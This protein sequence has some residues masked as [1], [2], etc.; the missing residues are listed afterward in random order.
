MPS[1]SMAGAT[2]RI[3][4][5]FS[6]SVRR[7]TRSRTRCSKGSSGFRHAGVCAAAGPAPA[8]TAHQNNPR[9]ITGGSPRSPEMHCPVVHPE[10]GYLAVRAQHEADGVRVVERLAP[11][12]PEG[13][14]L[15]VL[16]VAHLLADLE[17]QV[18]RFRPDH[19]VPEEAIG[20][21]AGVAVQRESG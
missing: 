8:R 20:V 2:S 13:V 9:G 7:P 18:A 4:E 3:W 12:D 10:L 5:T 21:I 11:V 16:Q 15:P 6:S 14:V 1:R 19:G 17:R